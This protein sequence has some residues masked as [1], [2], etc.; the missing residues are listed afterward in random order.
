MTDLEHPDALVIESDA[1]EAEEAHGVRL[2]TTER[3]PRIVIPLCGE[4][5]VLSVKRAREL[6]DE[7]IEIL[8][9]VAP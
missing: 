6:R 2:W 3:G 5:H 4:D 9:G 7:L 1:P 8:R